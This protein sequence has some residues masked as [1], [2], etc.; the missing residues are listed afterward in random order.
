VKSHQRF[1]ILA[2][3]REGINP[4]TKENQMFAAKPASKGVRARAVKAIRDAVV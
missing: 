1:P 4:F 3:A 2:P